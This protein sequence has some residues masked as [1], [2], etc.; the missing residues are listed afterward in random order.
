[1]SSVSNKPAR[2]E[3]SQA[4][5]RIERGKDLRVVLDLRDTEHGD[6]R[7]PDDENRTEH[8][9]DAGRTLEL[10]REQPGQE[11]RS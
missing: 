9:A 4:V 1:M 8:D 3:I 6:R 2:C 11:C 5:N 10:N 7:E